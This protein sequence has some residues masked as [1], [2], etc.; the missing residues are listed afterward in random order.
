MRKIICI[1]IMLSSTCLLF[2]Q[3]SL[4]S[5]IP[6]AYEIVRPD[7]KSYAYP[8][9]KPLTISYDH[10]G[11]TEYK[12]DYLDK[13]VEEGEFKNNFRFKAFGNFPIF[14][15][16]RWIVTASMNYLHEEFKAISTVN[17]NNTVHKDNFSVDDLSLTFSALYR[18]SLFNRP[19]M[20]G[21]NLI[22]DSRNFTSIQRVRG[23]VSATLV[24]KR[25]ANTAISTGLVAFVDPSVQF[26][27]FPTI[28]Y[29]HKFKNSNWEFDAILPARLMFRRSNTFK[30]WFS[31]GTELGGNSF[32]NQNGITS[33]PG[34]YEY[35]YSEIRAGITY[36]YPLNKFLLAGIKGGV[37]KTIM[38]RMGEV[39]AKR[40]DYLIETNAK[41]LPYVSVSLSVMIPKK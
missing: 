41:A 17:Y 8:I 27:V 32:F 26:P 30:G 39:N 13:R 34:D 11:N 9:F 40:K 14:A 36:E 15:K 18:D 2:A 3:D 5:K 1:A 6:K 33:L 25:T 37:S 22:L 38:S 7:S 4:D 29:W 23:M 10:L 35:S 20:Y 31:V 19:V 16:K 28:T 12:T 21:A 24:L